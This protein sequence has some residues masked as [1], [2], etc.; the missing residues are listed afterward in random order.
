MFASVIANEMTPSKAVEKMD[1]YGLINDYPLCRE[2]GYGKKIFRQVLIVLIILKNTHL[3]ISYV[4]LI[5]YLLEITI[6]LAYII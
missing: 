6:F 3:K 4:T 5:I 2:C 1:M